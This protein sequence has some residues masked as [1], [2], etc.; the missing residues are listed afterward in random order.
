MN[1]VDA[2][3]KVFSSSERVE[4]NGLVIFDL[5]FDN[6]RLWE[7]LFVALW[8]DGLFCSVEERNFTV[9]EGMKLRISVSFAN[10]SIA[11]PVVVSLLLLSSLEVSMGHLVHSRDIGTLLETSLIWCDALLCGH[12][13]G[14]RL[15][16]NMIVLRLCMSRP[17]VTSLK[18]FAKWLS[19]H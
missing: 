17:V 2:L 16:E 10:S 13:C 7:I 18:S 3:T 4:S 19:N 6:N 5:F 12:A 9:T 11:L 15:T 8:H 1:K 14:C